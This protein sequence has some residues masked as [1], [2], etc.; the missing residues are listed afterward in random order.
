MREKTTL[1]ES[2]SLKKISSENWQVKKK[3]PIS[4]RRYEKQ[5]SMRV[6]RFEKK[7]SLERSLEQK[8]YLQEFVGT[9]R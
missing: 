3:N 1:R 2:E 7:N 8:K 9:E 6:R 4:V 5:K